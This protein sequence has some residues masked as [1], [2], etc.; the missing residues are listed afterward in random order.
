M[1]D[2]GDLFRQLKEAL[3]YERLEAIRGDICK[4]AEFTQVDETGKPFKLGAHHRAWY[5]I[6]W[7]QVRDIAEPGKW[8]APEKRNLLLFAPRNHGKTSTMVCLL[9]Y[10]LGKNSLL[11]IKYVSRNDDIALAVVGQVKNNI[12]HNP[13]LHE[14][15][16]NLKKDPSGSWSG[17]TLDVLKLGDDGEIHP[18]GVGIKDA[19]LQAYGVTAPATGGR[20]DLIIFDDII[21]GREAIQ[22]PGRLEKITKAFD[23]DWMNIGG[24]RH[25]AVGTPWTAD[26][27]LA[28]IAQKASW[29]VWRK[30]AISDEG[31]ALWPEERPI[32]WLMA[33]R[34]E[35]GDPA[36]DLQFRLLG[37]K[38]KS[39]WW[40]Q[41]IIDRCKDHVTSFGSIP[42]D[43]EI[44]GVTIGFDPA[45]SLHTTGSYS[46]IFC[47]LYDQF[48]RKLPFRIVRDRKKPRIMADALVDM[49][50]EVEDVL[51]Y[52]LPNG[53]VAHHNVN[54]IHVENNATQEA[55]VDLIN[56][57]CEIRHL[58]LKIP[59]R[60]VNTSSQQKWGPEMGLMKMAS[61]FEVG[62]W[63]IPFGGEKHHRTDGT[64]WQDPLHDCPI[65]Q[66]VREMRKYGEMETTTD[67]IMSAWLA[68]SAIDRPAIG[69]VSATVQTRRVDMAD[70]QW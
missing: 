64:E 21:G 34:E 63:I 42:K 45:A 11:R 18:A 8:P 15:F 56:S 44:A 51:T 33:Q 24:K 12:E 31:R 23:M 68:S 13:R 30:P 62:K 58:T 60:G 19:N 17:S 14:V 50:L 41:A 4:F 20:A 70:V 25:I 29:R 1:A 9:Q 48:K 61:E 2:S 65:C 55:F 53:T 54:M 3:E 6:I 36:F 67:L 47:L 22:E 57:V 7:E 37:L 40:T 59:M 10:L 16:P 28:R 26:D 35:I 69:P 5:Q 52:K 43:F 32:E 39:D 46:A 27:I 66:W 49:L 38:G